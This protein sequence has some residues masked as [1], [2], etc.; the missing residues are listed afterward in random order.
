MKVQLES[1]NKSILPF[2]LIYS[3]DPRMF[4]F[5]NALKGIILDPKFRVKIEKKNVAITSGY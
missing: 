5:V 1:G 2:S 4:I 3:Y